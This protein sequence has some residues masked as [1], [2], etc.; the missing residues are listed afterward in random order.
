MG[1]LSLLRPPL[2]AQS[3]ASLDFLKHHPAFD[4]HCHPGNFPQR[5]GT[6][7]KGDKPF[8]RTI[9]EMRDGGL[10]AGFFSIIAD[11]RLLGRDAKGERVVNRAA[12]SGE[13][14]DDCKGN[15]RP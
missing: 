1:L 9:S 10:A 4:L 6:E 7:Y 8:A 2:L 11:A 13:L 15:W 5:G 14:W 12:A 3:A